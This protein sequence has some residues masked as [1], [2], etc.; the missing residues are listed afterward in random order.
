M[1][2]LR[3]WGT[4]PIVFFVVGMAIGTLPCCQLT[5]VPPPQTISKD[6]A[7][8]FGLVTEAWNTIGRHYVDRS[9]IKSQTLTYGAIRGMVDAL[10]DTGHSHFLSPEMVK[11]ERNFARGT[12]EGIGAEIRMKNGQVVIVAPMDGTARASAPLT[13]SAPRSGSAGGSSSRCHPSSA[14]PSMPKV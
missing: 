14:P 11:Q 3:P 7:P 9:A 6:A 5:R 1:R 10:G 13:C 8:N 2:Q 12:L 4:I